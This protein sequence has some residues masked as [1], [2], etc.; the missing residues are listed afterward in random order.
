MPPDPPVTPDRPPPRAPRSPPVRVDSEIGRLRR[1]LV[2][3][4]GPEVDQMVPGMMEELLFDDILFGPAARDEH[5]RFRR[6]LSLLGVEVLEA[7]G[8]LARAL[9][10]P[11]GRRWVE[12]RVFPDLDA[13][14][15]D[16]F[17]ALDP[18]G[19]ARAL[20]AGVRRPTVETAVTLDDLFGVRP[21]PNWCFQRD[22]QVVLGGSVHISSMASAARRREA[23]L[24]RAIFRFHPDLR[25]TPIL[26]DQGDVPTRVVL[27]GGDVLVLSPDI[28]AVGESARTSEG[29]L[30]ALID[31]LRRVEGGPRWLLRVTLPRE[32]AFMHLDTLF[33]PVDEDVCL[34]YPPVILPDRPGSARVTEYDLHEREATPR[35]A[36][37]LLGALAARGLPYRAVSCGGADPVDQ[38]REQWTDGA[39]ALAVAPGVAVLYDRNVRTAEAMHEAGFRIVRADDLLLGSADVSLDAGEKVCIL[40]PSNEL[41][42]ARGGPHCLTH[43][44]LRDPV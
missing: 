32:R 4:P 23:V 24:S 20:V 14:F 34:V 33:T 12:G 3:E 35:D 21:L 1:V 42:R 40:T 43:P 44:L 26:E 13:E 15:Q 5:R 18:D 22:T 2:H 17:R 7:Q 36:G 38:Q 16:R 19:A 27:E 8:L 6:V 28:V 31:R 39:N 41:S 25:D 10:D 11:E 9:A 37:D 29:G 30:D